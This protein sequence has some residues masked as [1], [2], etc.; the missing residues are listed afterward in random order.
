MVRLP[1][2]AVVKKQAARQ[3]HGLRLRFQ[4][5]HCPSGP[6][7][8]MPSSCLEQWIGCDHVQDVFQQV[9]GAGL[10]RRDDEPVGNV[11]LA[12]GAWRECSGHILGGDAGPFDGRHSRI[13]EGVH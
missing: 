13:Y 1:A 5:G 10:L 11:L 7:E 3:C 12:E 8:G 9:G 2:P 4:A 6:H